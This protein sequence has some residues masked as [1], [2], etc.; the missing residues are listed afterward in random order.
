MTKHVIVDT[1]KLP[2]KLY[3]LT[4]LSSEEISNAPE[5]I[6]LPPPRGRCKYSSLSR[7]SLVDLLPYVK[8]VK[9]RKPGA[10]R[11]IILIHLKSL[12]TYF[13]A[14]MSTPTTSPVNKRRD[15]AARS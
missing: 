10:N 6:R 5:F 11:G 13:E 9:L 3:R 14:R 1:P 15:K 2:E 7:S 12:Q 8:H 4:P